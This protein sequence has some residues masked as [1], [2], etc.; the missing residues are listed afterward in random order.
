[1]KREVRVLRRAQRDLVEIQTYVWR[2]NPAA[3]ERLV[4]DLL[5]QIERLGDFP[6]R[7]AL[8]KDSRLRAAGYR[9]VA[10]GEYI[11]FY[12]VLPSVLRIYRVLHGRR[13]YQHVL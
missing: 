11:L 12:K 1:M 13:R 10:R 5:R 2:D 7:G 9:H 4:E 6:L 8:A 3:A